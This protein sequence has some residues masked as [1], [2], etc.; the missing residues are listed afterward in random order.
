MPA[1]RLLGNCR[2]G[3]Q[4]TARVHSKFKY[5]AND[6]S[7]I[8]SHYQAYLYRTIRLNMIGMPLSFQCEPFWVNTP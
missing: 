7:R 5:L 3:I 8:T 4:N 6:L 2:F 1:T